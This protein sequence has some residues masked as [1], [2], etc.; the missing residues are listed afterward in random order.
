MIGMR[1]TSA[2]AFLRDVFT[3]Q[4]RK[5]G[6]RRRSDTVVVSTLNDVDPRSEEAF[7]KGSKAPPAPSEKS[8]VSGFRG[9]YERKY[10]T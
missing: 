10:E 1:L 2:K 9:E 7:Q 5:L 3:D 6:D 4:E 8:R